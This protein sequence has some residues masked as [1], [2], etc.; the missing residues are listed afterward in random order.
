MTYY[1]VSQNGSGFTAVWPTR[2]QIYYARLDA[3]GHLLPP[4]EIK[5]PGRAGIRTGMVALDA[6][7]GSTL[8]AWRQ[9]DCVKWQLYDAKG[10]PSGSVGSAQSAGTGVAGVVGRSGQL[11]LLR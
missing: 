1:A 3:K 8:V 11:I 6:P 10:Q 4:G 9:D 7:N 5:T 2:G